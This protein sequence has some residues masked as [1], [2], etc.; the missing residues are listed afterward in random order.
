MIKTTNTLLDDYN[1]VI[2]ETNENDTHRQSQTLFNKLGLIKDEI[3]QIVTACQRAK[4]GIVYSQLLNKGY[5]LNIL[6]QTETIPYRN[7]L[8]VLQFAKP[9][10]V[11]KDS[12][13]LNIISLPQ[14]EDM[15]F[16]NVILK[17]TVQHNKRI[18]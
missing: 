15:L 11:I 13:F 6:S 18:Y 12:L 8:Q 2:A 14:T 5:I 10:M 1:R 3:A 9:S 16:N 7:E 17:F 4:N